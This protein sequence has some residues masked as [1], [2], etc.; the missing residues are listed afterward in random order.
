MTATVIIKSAPNLRD[1]GDHMTQ[2]GGRIRTGLL[3]RSENLGRLSDQDLASLAALGLAKIYDLRTAGE[4]A[5]QPDRLPA[6]AEH[7]VVDVLAGEKRAAPAE[8]LHLLSNPQEANARLGGGKVKDLFTQS[9]REFVSLPSARTGFATLFTEFAGARNLP[10]LF[11]CTTGKDRTGWAAAA[12]LTLC[13]VPYEDVLRDYLVS[14]D[15]IL[16]EYQE[17][18]NIY[19][20]KGVD[21]EILQSVLGVRKEYLESSFAEMRDCFGDIEGYFRIGLGIGADEQ[22]RLREIFVE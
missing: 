10:A 21:E 19:T 2:T 20:T 7:M 3:Y 17:L 4:I 13:D 12:L 6:G 18:I 8:L 14:N 1:M 22:Q 16:P 11:H 9:Y 5:E 15:F